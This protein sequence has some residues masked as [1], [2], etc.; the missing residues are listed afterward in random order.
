MGEDRTQFINIEED[1]WKKTIQKTDS[2]MRLK[3]ILM[4]YPLKVNKQEETF[5][6]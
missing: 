3:L 4:M 1:H 2:E 5:M 6:E